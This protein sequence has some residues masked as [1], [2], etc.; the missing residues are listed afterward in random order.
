MR[1]L[2]VY[3]INLRD[4]SKGY[5]NTKSTTW[6]FYLHEILTTNLRPFNFF[7]AFKQP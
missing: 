3:N 6:H 2:F 1:Q 4:V 7:G 5:K